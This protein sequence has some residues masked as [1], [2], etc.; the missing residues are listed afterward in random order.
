M[1]CD[2]DIFSL[3]NLYCSIKINMEVVIKVMDI[4]NYFGWYYFIFDCI[5]YFFFIS[6]FNL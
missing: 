6:F 1:F 2:I 4:L 3:C 5:F